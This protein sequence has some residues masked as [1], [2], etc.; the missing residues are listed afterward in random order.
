MCQLPTSTPVPMLSVMWSP[1]PTLAHS[2]SLTHS[3]CKLSVPQRNT[4]VRSRRAHRK[5]DSRSRRCQHCQVVAGASGVGQNVGGR[6][7]RRDHHQRRSHHF[8]ESGSGTSSSPRFGG[9]G[10]TS[11]QGSGRWNHVRG[12]H[13]SRAVAAGQ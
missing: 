10:A 1:F 4:R 8:E 2:L 7:W 11:G 5:R 9:P 6:H 13:C 3:H 12:Y